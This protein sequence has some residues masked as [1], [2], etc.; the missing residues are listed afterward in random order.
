MREI[1]R[2]VK[3]SLNQFFADDDWKA[4]AC[5]NYMHDDSELYITGY[6]YGG[7]RLV[8]FALSNE[9]EQ[10]VLIYPIVFQY[11]HYI[12]LRLKKIIK[13]GRILLEE[14]G[15]FPKHHDIIKLWNIAKPISIKVFEDED[16]QLELDHA[17]H[18]I[19]E[20]SQI[21]PNSMNFRYPTTKKGD[22][23]ITGVTHINIRRFSD[24]MVKLSI[25][26]EHIITGIMYLRE[27]QSEI[28]SSGYEFG[29]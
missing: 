17:E 9:M 1:C 15:V 24:H 5:L 13:E 2:K 14:E 27:F 16:E 10:D 20:F 19:N 7:D 25:S 18:V 6:K 8:E 4:N 22:K 21:D 3:K 28:N 11:R 23:S 29:E 26:L 12:E